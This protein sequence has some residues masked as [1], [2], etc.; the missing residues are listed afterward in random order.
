M[1]LII[2]KVPIVASIM[3]SFMKNL[4]PFTPGTVNSTFGSRTV[5][6]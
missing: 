5:C 4:A 3:K 1:S 6:G 2:A